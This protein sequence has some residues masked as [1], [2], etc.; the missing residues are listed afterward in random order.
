MQLNEL[1]KPISTA[2]TV[3]LLSKDFFHSPVSLISLWCELYKHLLVE[4]KL[5]Q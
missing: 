4:I 1:D 3:I 5:Y 2:L